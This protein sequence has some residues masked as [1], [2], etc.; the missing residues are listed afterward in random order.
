MIEA[1]IQDI[2][3]DLS[4]SHV[5]A[6]F[7]VLKTEIGEDD[8]YIRIKCNLLNGDIFEFAAYAILHKEKIHV[9]TYSYHWQSFDGK[10]RKRWDNVPHHK[11]FDTFPNHLHL[12]DKVIRSGPRFL[13]EIL[14]DIEKALN[15]NGEIGN[16]QM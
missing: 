8:G 5:V 11:N 15:L 4:I 3:Q 12:P 13:K 10:L 1:Y 6:S 2:I 9:E 16:E 14:T 7:R